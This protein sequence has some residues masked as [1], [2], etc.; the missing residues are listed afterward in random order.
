MQ[1][2]LRR[3]N[4][5]YLF[6]ISEG[7]TSPFVKSG[8]ASV[9]PGQW[10]HVV[11]TWDGS[12][13][14]IYVDGVEMGSNATG[15]IS[16]RTTANKVG[17]GGNAFNEFFTGQIDN[18]RIWSSMR[19][20]SEINTT[21]NQC[22]TGSEAD[23]LAL[24]TFEDGTGSTTLTDETG[25]GYNGTL[26]LMD[27]T[28][29]WVGSVGGPQVA[30]DQT[31]TAAESTVCPNG[32]ST[33]VDLGSSEAPVVYYLRDDSDNSIIDGP[34]QG[35]GSGISLNT[36]IVGT[37]TT[38]NVRGIKPENGIDLDGADDIISAGNSVASDLDGL[39][40]V[41]V[42]AWVKPA[43]TAGFGVVA[44]NYNYPT[45]NNELQ[46]LLR[47]SGDAY[48]FYVDG[49]L[50][51]EGVITSAG[52][53]IPGVWQHVAGTWDGTTLRI[54]INGVELNS[55]TTTNGS[56]LISTANSLVMGNNA[57]NESFSGIIDDVRIWTTTRTATE[58][59]QNMTDCLT[60]SET[61]L[62]AYYKLNELSGATVVSDASASGYDATLMNADP[63]AVWTTGIVGC[64]CN[65]NMSTTVTV[66]VEDI[67]DPVL[68]NVPANISLLANAANCEATVTWTAPT[69]TDN[70]TTS[71][72]IT[73]TH[74][75]GDNFP[76][77]ITTVSYTATDDEGN[78]VVETFDVTVTSDLVGTATATDVLCNGDT[79]GEVTLVVTG[80][81]T[82]YS[83]EWD[84]ASTSTT[85]DLTG[86]GAGTY[87][88]DITDA[89]GC[90][91]TVTETVEEPGALAATSATSP[92]MNGN[93]GSI[94]LT[95][96]GGIAP[97]TYD[98][99]GPNGYTSLGEDLTGLEG[100]SY[101]VTITDDNGCTFV[102]QVTVDSF[103]GIVELKSTSF[104][105]YPN[106]S[107][108]AFTIDTPQSGTLNVLTTN[109]QI[110]HS[111]TIKS[112]KTNFQLSEL[113]TGVYVIQLTT[114]SDFQVRRLSIK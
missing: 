24:Y 65:A 27:E 100:G 79:D 92:E 62:I 78:D 45:N 26:T 67:T 91:T 94:D 80:G 12:T 63:S 37:T 101:E 96:T 57:I 75:S 102:T 15:A 114:M 49:G 86:A 18:V 71:P 47:R 64:N 85:Q 89:N 109:G 8:V 14:K 33:T 5:E 17:V 76:L 4:D 99:I 22:L 111:T 35:T 108:G 60:G 54:Y 72:A 81:T 112:G 36:G 29:D 34:T 25:N 39:S 11:G 56:N 83:Y 106:P 10:Q 90:T 59:G 3:D 55:F 87:T 104:N 38:Y 31:L 44:G 113:S 30:L 105:I 19:T 77:G 41:T 74:N 2:L 82:T 16:L 88:V 52:T 7:G 73:S 84:D 50:G 95:A 58:V 6:Q 13:M 53:V 1:F 21:M 46:I 23:L 9:I 40:N 48:E 61:G 28:T 107:N 20:A 69:A 97:Y 98:W 32:G 66:T 51:Y 103:V 70:C 68:A 93:D 42:E 110:I 43:T